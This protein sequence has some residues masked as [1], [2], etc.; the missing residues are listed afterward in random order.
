M[1]E[2]NDRLV[3]VY[4]DGEVRSVPLA[5]IYVPPFWIVLGKERPCNDIKENTP[6]G[7]RGATSQGTSESI[8]KDAGVS[9]E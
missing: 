3:L 5:S 7:L 1:I 2:M 6:D 9:R 4:V 8:S